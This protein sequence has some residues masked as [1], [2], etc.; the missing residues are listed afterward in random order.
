MIETRQITHSVHFG[1]VPNPNQ[2][3]GYQN[4]FPDLI[5][6]PDHIGFVLKNRCWWCT[7]LCPHMAQFNCHL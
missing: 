5:G 3:A 4:L 1:I 2:S 7:G 6:I